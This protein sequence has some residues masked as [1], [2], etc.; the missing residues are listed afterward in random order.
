MKI[1]TKITA[2]AVMLIGAALW[3]NNP[4]ASESLHSVAINGVH[5]FAYAKE[6][7]RIMLPRGLTPECKDGVREKA[8]SAFF[9]EI[10]QRASTDPN[11]SSVTIAYFDSYAMS[12]DVRT[13]ADGPYPTLFVDYRPGDEKQHWDLWPIGANGQGISGLDDPKGI[14]ASLCVVVSGRGAKVL[15]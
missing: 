9:G 1:G 11:C 12:T 7:C 3:C 4:A 15:Q 6:V 2:A 13:I 10:M 14:A 8:V 5:A